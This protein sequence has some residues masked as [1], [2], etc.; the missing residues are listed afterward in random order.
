MAKT[1][2]FNNVKKHYLTVTL[3][4][5]KSTT[6]FIGTPN[7]RAMDEL[8]AIKESLDS[9]EDDATNVEALDDL[10][11]ACAKIMSRNKTGKEITKEFLEELF[12]IEDIIIFFDAYMDFVTELSDSKN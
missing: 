7:K 6:L 5:E 8:L 4:D 10:Y 2:N 3:A 12:D 9:I 11:S 1:L